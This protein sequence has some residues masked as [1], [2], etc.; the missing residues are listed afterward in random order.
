MTFDD[1]FE[2]DI[3]GFMGRRFVELISLLQRRVDGNW[4]LIEP[5][6]PIVFLGTIV[7]IISAVL[8]T[9]VV[10]NVIEQLT[11]APACNI[12]LLA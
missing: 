9:V 3:A 4:T 6:E 5:A 8:F 11:K 7:R 12:T 1:L 10:L 2:H